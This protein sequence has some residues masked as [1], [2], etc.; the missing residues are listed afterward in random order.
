MMPEAVVD[1]LQRREARHEGRL[2]SV[3][4]DFGGRQFGAVDP[5]VDP[6]SVDWSAVA[7]DSHTA[8]RGSPDQRMTYDG[9]Y[10]VVEML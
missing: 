4:V 8:L 6:A 5:S 9:R 1:A 2:P 10:F 3:L 7:V